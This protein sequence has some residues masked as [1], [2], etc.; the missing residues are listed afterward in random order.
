MIYGIITEIKILSDNYIGEIFPELSHL[1]KTETAP[2]RDI[3]YHRVNTN[4]RYRI[5]FQYCRD[6]LM[7]RVKYSPGRK[8]LI[9]RAQQGSILNIAR[10]G[11]I[12]LAGISFDAPKLCNRWGEKPPMKC[13]AQFSLDKT[14]D[15]R[16]SLSET[17]RFVNRCTIWC[18]PRSSFRQ[19]E[20]NF[21]RAPYGQSEQKS[22]ASH[23]SILFEDGR[24]TWRSCF[25]F[26]S[27][28][29]SAGATRRK[30]CTY[31]GH[32]QMQIRLR[33]SACSQSEKSGVRRARPA[34]IDREGGEGGRGFASRIIR[35][36]SE[37]ANSSSFLPRWERGWE[38]AAT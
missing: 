8:T 38:G 9:L 21:V 17:E 30:D 28:S 11:L 34:E 14:H 25:L 26:E 6:I 27:Q 32:D 33:C 12:F 29:L 19:I 31:L 36:N 18:A 24:G 37:S 4:T 10:C 13:R 1:L 16:I 2:Y 15:G 22:F 20:F 23:I 5:N 3:C 35:I 7:P